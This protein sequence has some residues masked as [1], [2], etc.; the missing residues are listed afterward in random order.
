MPGIFSSAILATERDGRLLQ[1]K[2]AQPLPPGATI[3]AKVAMATGVSALAVG[4]VAAAAI[5]AGKITLS[6]G[7]VAIVWAVLVLGAIPFSAIGL[8][9]GSRVS[10]SAAPAWGNL[11]FLPMIYL[12]GLFIPLPEGL[13]KWVVVWPTFHLDQLALALAGCVTV[14]ADGSKPDGSTVKVYQAE[15]ASKDT[16]AP[17]MPAGC[18]LV[19]QSGPVD[20][21]QQEFE[22]SNPYRKQR[23][24]TAARGGNVL[25]VPFYRFRNLMKLDCPV[26]DS[27][28]GCMDREQSWYKVTF[29][30]YA[31]DEPALQALAESPLPVQPAVFRIEFKKR[32]AA[33][34]AAAASAAAAPAPPS[35][36]AAVSAVSRVVLK[37]RV[38]ALMQEGVGT[39]VIVSYAR[40]NRPSPPLTADEIIDWKKSG[41]SDAVIDATFPK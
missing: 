11:L 16:M 21:Q 34:P 40:A 27:S 15:L 19:G 3:V 32:P 2:R 10:G 13:K 7:Q 25:Y 35:P 6:L 12:S 8:F 9:L 37:E 30:S 20:Q 38:L 5:L 41:I 23:E 4:L 14:T 24:D 26:G 18:R 28:P 29:K 39:D 31:C 33:E 36:A 22:I 17:P 1:L